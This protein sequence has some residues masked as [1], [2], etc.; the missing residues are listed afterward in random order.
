MRA[1]IAANSSLLLLLLLLLATTSAVGMTTKQHD[2]PQGFE[3]AIVESD[4]RH[5]IASTVNGAL[6]RH[7]RW[8]RGASHDESD[9]CL[10][11]LSGRLLRYRCC[12][13]ASNLAMGLLHFRYADGESLGAIDAL[14]GASLD[15]VMRM[16]AVVSPQR[17]AIYS[18][19]LVLARGVSGTLFKCEFGDVHTYLVFRAD[20]ARIDDI[21]V[22]VS[23]RQFLL[24][25]DLV[26]PHQLQRAN[27]LRLFE[28]YEPTF[29]GSESD[30]VHRV[31]NRTAMAHRMQRIGALKEPAFSNTVPF[32]AQLFSKA[33]RDGVCGRA[34]QQ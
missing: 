6:E 3:Q 8:M 18:L 4:L 29:V 10:N 32:L 1:R 7:H 33:M 25:L 22:D 17:P 26:E 27:E 30:I 11:G 21:I 31:F 24:F 34:T 5:F 16:F 23:Y 13:Y 15:T 2:L 14:G 12:V 19:R 28:P 9:V 20:N